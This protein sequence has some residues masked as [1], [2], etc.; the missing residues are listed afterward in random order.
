[1]NIVATELSKRFNREWIFHKLSYRFEF[2]KTYALVGP[3]GSG[4]STLLHI[5]TGQVPPTGGTLNYEKGKDNIN[6]HE[7]YK[8]MVIAAPYI[9]LIDEFT[10]SEMVKFHFSFKQISDGNSIDD[11]ID[12]MELTHARHKFVSNFSS[13]MRQRLKLGLA[14]FSKSEVL[15]LDEPTSNLD[16]KS[17]DWYWKNLN[18]LIGKKLIILASNH[19]AEYPP[20]AEKVDILR[21]KKAYKA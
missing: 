14:F 1:M 15:F 8:S 17:I 16:Q 7:V 18:P 5:L 9:D 13:G 20:T 4:K 11:M 12:K 3:N 6:S 21:F 2:G 19:E 10:L